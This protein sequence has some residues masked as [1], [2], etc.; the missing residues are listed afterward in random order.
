MHGTGW[1]LDG[2]GRLAAAHG[3][4]D[5]CILYGWCRFRVI[6]FV[7]NGIG[8]IQCIAAIPVCHGGLRVLGG[9][10]WVQTSVVKFVTDLR[11]RILQCRHLL[12]KGMRDLKTIATPIF[13]VGVFH[14]MASGN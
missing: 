12:A 4:G 9:R 13:H 11:K 2:Q 8:Q 14:D 3:N 7:V 6:D 1:G 5:Q 10:R